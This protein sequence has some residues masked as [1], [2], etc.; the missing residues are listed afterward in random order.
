MESNSEI[1]QSPTGGLA[2]YLGEFVYGGLDGCVTTFAVVSGAVGAELSANIILILGMA[3]LLA[4]GF[5]MSIGAYLSTRSRQDHFKNQLAEKIKLIKQDKKSPMDQLKQIYREKGLEESLIGEVSLAIA[6][7][8]QNWAEELMRVEENMVVDDR[9]AVKIAMATY[10]S[11]I[12]VGLVPLLAYIF[13]L[14]CKGVDQLFLFSCA[15]T[16]AGFI[17]IGWLKTYVAKTSLLKGIGETLLLGAAAATVSYFV[18]D[19]LEQLI[20]S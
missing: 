13:D 3:N 11:F 12:A 15:F 2:N 9:S 10:V 1:K 16:A 4:D 8:N 18:G 7:D 5:A 17:I 20:G 14:F 6:R 19:I